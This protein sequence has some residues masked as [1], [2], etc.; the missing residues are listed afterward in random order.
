M[1][2]LDSECIPDQFIVRDP[3]KW[4]KADIKQLGAHWRSLEDE[5]KAIISFIGARKDDL[6]LEK[7][8]KIR[9]TGSKKPWMDIEDSEEE[10]PTASFS[11]SEEET[12]KVSGKPRGKSTSAKN[13]HEDSP[14]AH[15]HRDQIQFL[16]SLSIM[17][18]YQDLIN[19]ACTLS[20]VVSS[21]IVVL[22]L[23][24]VN[25]FIGI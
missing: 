7:P 15:S 18:Q 20:K 19:I 3:S 10:G 16:R 21:I 17:P 5:G 13:P 4:T 23:L 24:M 14:Y 9:A 12:N 6:P 8:T 2:Y 11:D 1:D 22:Y 25:I